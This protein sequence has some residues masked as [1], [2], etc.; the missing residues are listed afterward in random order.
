MA[1]RRVIVMTTVLLLV[2]LLAG[3][4]GDGGVNQFVAT[5]NARATQVAGGADALT[6]PGAI[7]I[8]NTPE[9]TIPPAPSATPSVVV[10]DL[11]PS[12]TNLLASAWGQ[13]YAL[14]AGTQFQIIA[15]ERQM[16][17]FI[18]QTLQLTGYET[19]VRG[20]QATIGSGQVRLDMALVGEDGSFGGGTIT[21][22]PTLDAAGRIR[23]NPLGGDFGSLP[24]PSALLS[25]FGDAVH[26]SL[27]GA[28]SGSVSKVTLSSITLDGGLMTV[29]GVVR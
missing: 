7:P 26:T 2:T 8:F 19:Y 9:P 16:G 12:P 25:A 13:V 17:D 22:Q 20:G 5:M 15:T 21:F 3:C 11:T 10:F 29:N 28:A 14:P 23:I 1:Q 24:L 6:T 4:R 27:A 18:I